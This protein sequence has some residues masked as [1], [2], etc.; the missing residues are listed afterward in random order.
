MIKAYDGVDAVETI[1]TSVSLVAADSGKVFFIA[2]DA[3]VI[4]LPSTVAGVRYT[5]VNTGADD[6]NSIVLS[7]AAADGIFG[8]ITVAASV[9]VYDG[10]AD[11]DITN[12]ASGANLGDFVTI[13]GDGDQGWAIVAGV[14]IW[15]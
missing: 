3:L 6:N 14:G 1:T 12:T 5:F 2:T 7:P 4:T 15:A 11:T 8:S 9:T 10:T 13:V